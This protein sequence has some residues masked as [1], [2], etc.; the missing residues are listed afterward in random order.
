VA[1]PAG[2]QDLLSGKKLGD[3]VELGPYG[4]AVLK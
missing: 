4:V 1:V 3:T 2:K